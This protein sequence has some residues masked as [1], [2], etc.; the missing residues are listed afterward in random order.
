MLLISSGAEV[1][2]GQIPNQEQFGI[3][4]H[5][6]DDD[7]NYDPDDDNDD[8]GDD[9]LICILEVNSQSRRALNLCQHSLDF[10]AVFFIFVS[11]DICN[12]N[13]IQNCLG[14]LGPGWV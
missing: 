1:T 3:Q 7:H 8:D 14:D 9:E 10:I 11:F 5:G 12:P 2:W 4:D 6:G 13:T